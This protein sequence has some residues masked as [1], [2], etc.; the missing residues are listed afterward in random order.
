L[1]K[2]IRYGTAKPGLAIRA[3]LSGIKSKSRVDDAKFD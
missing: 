3:A 1:I 2:A